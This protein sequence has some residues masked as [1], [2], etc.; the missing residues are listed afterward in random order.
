MALAFDRSSVRTVDVDGRLHVA[1][2]NISKAMVSPYYG[3]E[4]PDY[5]ELGLDAEKVYQLLRDPEELAKAAPTF[6]NLPV[7]SKHVPVSAD[8]HMPDLVVGSTG[9]DAAFNDPYLTNSAVIWAADAIDLIDSNKKKQWSCAYRYVADMTPGTYQGLRFDGIMRNIIGNHVALVEEGRVGADA[10]VADSKLET[11]GMLKSRKALLV[12]GAVAAYLAPRLAQDAKV[13]LK[14][15]LAGVTRSNFSARKAS[16]AAALTTAVTGKLAQDADI[17]DV[18]S[19]LDSLEAVT[20]GEMSDDMLGEAAEAVEEEKPAVDAD[21]DVVSKIMAFLKGKISDEDLAELS[22]MTGGGAA[23]EDTDTPNDPNT[24]NDPKS[25]TKAAMDAKMKEASNAAV[26]RMTAA[27]LAR[28]AVEPVIGKVSLALDSA[29]AIYKLALDH[30]G[31]DTAGVHVSAYAALLKAAHRPVTSPAIA[32]DAANLSTAEA[33][34]R[35]ENPNASILA[36]S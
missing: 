14:P 3:A 9:T 23:D 15:V 17:G 24:A 27:A 28:E 2:S 25:L 34:F 30:L 4:I 35:K 36:R 33:K 19:L 26:A 11:A 16:I 32:Q 22:A 5:E 12:H 13:D 7:L 20:D 1:I 29:P 10:V 8:A 31:V 21:G 18:V 6:N